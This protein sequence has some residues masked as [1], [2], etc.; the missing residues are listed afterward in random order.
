MLSSFQLDDEYINQILE[1]SKTM[2]SE[3][4]NQ[5][6]DD[7][8]NYSNVINSIGNF[9]KNI[10]KNLKFYQNSSIFQ[11]D[12]R[13][14][15]FLIN[16]FFDC[17]LKSNKIP[18][19]S[20]FFKQIQNDI[21]SFSQIFNVF[22]TN[23]KRTFKAIKQSQIEKKICKKSIKLLGLQ[24]VLFNLSIKIE[25][26]EE[27]PFYTSQY[28]RVY[29]YYNS[30][31]NFEKPIAAF[32][33]VGGSGK[34]ICVPIMIL[35]R[36]LEEKMDTSFILMTEPNREI[37][38]EKTAF[39]RSNIG[40]YANVTDDVNNIIDSY[41]ET[42]NKKIILGILTPEELL[43]VIQNQKNKSDFFKTTR[44]I[45]DEVHEQS[46]YTDVILVL[47]KSYKE[48][49]QLPL[50]FSMMSATIK[51]NH[52]YIQFF[53]DEELNVTKLVHKPLFKVSKRS[54]TNGE[55]QAITD[56]TSNVIE[57]MAKMNSKIEEGH[58][59]CFV[60]GIESA[61]ILKGSIISHFQQ[62]EQKDEMKNVV[63]MKTIL[64]PNE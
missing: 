10:A 13:K 63:I 1:K 21:I 2:Q 7:L 41:N 15:V 30:I 18:K 60:Q 35:C 20:D 48:N 59:I 55:I 53:K 17:Y 12:F 14:S 29:R 37:V 38:E 11:E 64:K 50:S 3:I 9:L 56:E 61:Q 44:I 54:I 24:A 58:L 22:Y 16:S 33:S 47:I 26:K 5:S 62:F 40:N 27:V 28:L 34:S 23:Y 8:Q 57:E 39:F 52:R 43:Y 49:L 4:E 46:I 51:E 25:P 45:M 19:D 42:E 32:K 36:F 31:L 6:S